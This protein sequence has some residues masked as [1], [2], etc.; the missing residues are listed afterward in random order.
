MKQTQKNKTIAVT[1]NLFTSLKK[2]HL[3]IM[4]E[5]QTT[6]VTMNEVMQTLLNDHEEL[7]ELKKQGLAKE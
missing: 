3:N 4:N 6:D 1:E 7:R 2:V 5:K